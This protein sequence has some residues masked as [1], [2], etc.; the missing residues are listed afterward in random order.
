MEL[1]G[2]GVLEHVVDLVTALQ[3]LSLL[4]SQSLVALQTGVKWMLMDVIV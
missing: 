3:L 1:L 2:L 4:Q